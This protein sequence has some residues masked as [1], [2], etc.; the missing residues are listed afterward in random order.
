[1]NIL[2]SD[3]NEAVLERA[4]AGRYRELEVGR[5]LPAS[6]HAKYF[7]RRESEWEV[8]PEVRGMVTFRQL[9]LVEA[10]DGLEPCDLVF[11]RNVLI[12]FDQATKRSILKRLHHVLG[13]NGFLVL[14][15]AET[16]TDLDDAYVPLRVGDGVYY[17]LAAPP[18]LVPRVA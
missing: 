8:V 17:Q 3:L 5:G 9:N 18:S 16:P 6:Y 1:V 12:Y 11:M 7:V 4:R 14:G 10:W 13:Q 15:G 2:A